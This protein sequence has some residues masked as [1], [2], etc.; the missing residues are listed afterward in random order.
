MLLTLCFSKTTSSI[1]HTKRTTTMS[2]APRDHHPDTLHPTRENQ[3]N[4]I[5]QLPPPHQ[6]EPTW[7]P[8]CNDDGCGYWN[9]CYNCNDFNATLLVDKAEFLARKQLEKEYLEAPHPHPTL[10]RPHEF[11]YGTDIENDPERKKHQNWH[12]TKDHRITVIA[13]FIATDTAIASEKED[14]ATI[15]QVKA[16]LRQRRYYYETYLSTLTPE[17]KENKPPP[18]KRKKLLQR[19]PHTHGKELF[20]PNTATAACSP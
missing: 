14:L 4:D 8:S 16:E 9:R 3:W 17:S 20:L 6:A 18:Q 12:C 1:Q 11:N 7:R 10:L 2:H 15:K 5:G 13:L 19:H